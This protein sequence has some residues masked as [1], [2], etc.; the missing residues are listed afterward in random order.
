LGRTSQSKNRLPSKLSARGDEP[1][2]SSCSKTKA[3]SR[4]LRRASRRRWDL[5]GR[6]SC[7]SLALSFA[8]FACRA[9]RASTPETVL[10]A[11]GGFGG[12]VA[13]RSALAGLPSFRS[14]TRTD[15]RF[16]SPLFG[17][18]HSAPEQSVL[19]GLD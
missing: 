5:L 12:R 15:A 11:R 2:C 9:L 17:C 13:T 7:G 10:A 18:P 8:R 1:A 16:G 3:P 6:S 19:R 14:G 4:I